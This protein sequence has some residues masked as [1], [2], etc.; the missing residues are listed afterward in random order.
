MEKIFENLQK[1]PNTVVHHVVQVGN[2][3]RGD[4]STNYFRVRSFFESH[5]FGFGIGG[6]VSEKEYSFILKF[7]LITVGNEK[8]WLVLPLVLELIV[9]NLKKV[10][11]L[12]SRGPWGVI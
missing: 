10:K 4:F 9:L 5:G 8:G 1:L 3:I 7:F 11:I 12:S 6:R 2:C